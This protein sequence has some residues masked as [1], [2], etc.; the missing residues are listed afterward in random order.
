MDALALPRLPY[1]QVTNTHKYNTHILHT[2]YTTNGEKMSKYKMNKVIIT[3]RTGNAS[4][5]RIVAPQEIKKQTKYS[6]FHYEGKQ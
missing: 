6:T 3:T 1:M 2:T 5:P 4:H